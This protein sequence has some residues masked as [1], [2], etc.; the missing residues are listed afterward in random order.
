ME[1]G[2]PSMQ[3]LNNVSPANY[4]ALI[5]A[6]K[7]TN[8]KTVSGL[9]TGQITEHGLTLSYSYDPTGQ[10]FAWQAVHKPIFVTQQHIEDMLRAAMMPATQTASAQTAPA[11]TST[12]SGSAKGA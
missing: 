2:Y 3:Q 8:P 12:S 6:L 7:P 9:T 10:T 5:A 4:S 11:S 1:H